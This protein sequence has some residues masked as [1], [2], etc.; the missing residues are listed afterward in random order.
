[1]ESELVGKE[2]KEYEELSKDSESKL[3]TSAVAVVEVIES[4]ESSRM[5]GAGRDGGVGNGT[6]DVTVCDLGSIKEPRGDELGV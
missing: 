1:V 5:R 2:N 4:T 3:S 6:S